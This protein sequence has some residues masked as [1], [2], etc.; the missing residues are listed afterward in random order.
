VGRFNSFNQK[1][2]I[3]SLQRCSTIPYY[4][5]IPT[6]NEIDNIGELISRLTRTLDPLNIEYK[7][8]VVDDNSPDGTWKKVQEI[9]ENNKH[10]E[11]IIREK[12]EGIGAAIKHGIRYVLEKTNAEYVATM[13]ADLS[14]RPEDLAKMIRYSR[15]ADL[16]QASRYIEGGKIIGWGP[17]RK[18]ISWVA[19]TL[20]RHIYRTGLHEH[21]T[22]YRIYKRWLAEKIIKYT[23][24]KSY[25][26]VIEALLVSIA[27]G[28][29]IVE[30][31][32]TFIN[33]IK[34]KS[35]LGL[36]DILDWFKYIVTFRTRFKEIRS[37]CRESA[38]KS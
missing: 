23:R 2:D 5:I 35:K 15:D 34:G 3:S 7:I 22:N 37:V 11:L 31:P 16:V 25:E 20:V 21:T 24:S 10:V 27:C 8:L 29:K 26:W 36:I 18:L 4:V 6:Y 33:R 12:K 30:V 14:H 17:H 19:N 38:S 28:A 9:M 1:I 32:T 13:D